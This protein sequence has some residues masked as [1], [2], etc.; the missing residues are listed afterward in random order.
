ML[1]DQLNDL[2]LHITDEKKLQEQATLD[3]L[4]TSQIVI[5]S[6]RTRGRRR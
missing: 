2:M 5:I 1:R 4:T 3:E 6:K